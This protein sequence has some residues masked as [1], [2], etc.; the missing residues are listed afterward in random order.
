MNL[1]PESTKTF[2]EKLENWFTSDE[3]GKFASKSIEAGDFEVMIAP[4][5]ISLPAAVETRRI[6][7]RIAIAAQ[8]V[9]FEQ[10]GAYTGEISLPML[11]EIGCRYVIIGH[12]ERRH[13]FG[14]SDD[15]IERKLMA[16]LESNVLP[17]LCVGET[18]EEREAGDMKK[19]LKRQ[20]ESICSSLTS[21]VVSEMIVVAYEPVWAIGTGKA[22]TE[23]DADS[24]CGH[25][26]SVIEDR[27]GGAC[28]DKI[29][30]L[31]GGSVN[32]DNCADLL[33]HE[34]IDGLLIG[35]ASLDV[36]TFTKIIGKTT[37]SS[38]RTK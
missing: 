34:N 5:F 29:R 21:D 30:I 24:A 16:S 4:P 2:V 19:I 27:F 13:I 20:L 32:L 11:E 25:I 26:R 7:K 31:Y 3:I 22:A 35:G 12:S 17:I 37:P 15:L 1:G 18:L 8:N 9:F 33:K 36:S 6:E 38:Y 10:K 14:E 28:A 23:S